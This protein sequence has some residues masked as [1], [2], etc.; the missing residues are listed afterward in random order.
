MLRMLLWA[1]LPGDSLYCSYSYGVE[2]DVLFTHDVGMIACVGKYGCQSM[3][4]CYYLPLVI[5]GGALLRMFSKELLRCLFAGKSDDMK[6]T[7][8]AWGEQ[9]AAYLVGDDAHIKAE[10]DFYAGVE[11]EF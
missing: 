11:S 2:C 3:V 8:G 1:S 4:A 5:G 7:F 10:I 9:F 6:D